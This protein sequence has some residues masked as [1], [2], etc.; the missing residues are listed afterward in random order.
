MTFEGQTVQQS[1]EDCPTLGEIV[2]HNL[3]NIRAADCITLEQQ[4]GIEE[5]V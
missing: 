5:I 2:P 3:C 1:E 4:I